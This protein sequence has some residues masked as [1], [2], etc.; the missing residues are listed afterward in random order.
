[1]TPEPWPRRPSRMA[2]VERRRASAISPNPRM[3]GPPGPFADGDRDRAGRAAAHHF[4]VDRFAHRAGF[5]RRLDVVG[6]NHGAAAERKQ[7]V[8]DQHAGFGG[9][10]VGF[11]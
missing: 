7:N 8:A 5:E 3:S 1:M 11:E 4:G 2:T 9:G 10:P 6:I